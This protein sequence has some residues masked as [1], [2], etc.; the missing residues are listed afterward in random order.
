MQMKGIAM[1]M[2]NMLL[3]AA[4]IAASPVD[5]AGTVPVDH[6][7]VG[8]S[9]DAVSVL[10]LPEGQKIVEAVLQDPTG[11]EM[12]VATDRTVAFRGTSDPR[13]THLLIRRESHR[14]LD[15]LL[16]PAAAD[17][18]S[19]V[20]QIGAA[21]AARVP[22]WH[23]RSH[24]VSV[25]KPGFSVLQAYASTGVRVE[26]LPSDGTFV[27]TRGSRERGD[28]VVVGDGGEIGVYRLD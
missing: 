10:S 19:Q 18:R 5:S 7:T 13:G 15:V 22:E 2:T 21:G 4:A 14:P 16:L 11:V 27:A 23:V 28:V 1:M 25:L 8:V 17:A 26:V 9:Q 20:V 6:A 12:T 3:V 24:D